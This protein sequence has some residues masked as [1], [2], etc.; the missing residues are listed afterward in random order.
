MLLSPMNL[1][2][3]PLSTLSAPP[4]RVRHTFNP[5]SSITCTLF[6]IHQIS[7]RLFSIPYT[8]F[9]KSISRYPQ[10]FLRVA[11]SLPKTPGG[12]AIAKNI[13]LAPLRPRCPKRRLSPRHN[14]RPLRRLSYTGCGGEKGPV[15]FPAFKAGDS[16]LRGP[17]G[18]FD[19]HTP[20]PNIVCKAQ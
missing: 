9:S 5:S 1:A 2:A 20:P 15:T 8:L 7:H 17:N 14:S 19:S 11:H 10:Q 16:F 3:S 6:A 4:K 18:G 12:T 13:F